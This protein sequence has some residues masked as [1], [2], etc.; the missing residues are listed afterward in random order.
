MYG[1]ARCRLAFWVK[2]WVVGDR[3]IHVW[4]R[5]ASQANLPLLT[6]TT[7]VRPD[8][9]DPD[10]TARACRMYPEDAVRQGCYLARTDDTVRSR[11][12]DISPLSSKPWT[13]V[14][15]VTALNIIDKSF[16]DFLTCT[17][18]HSFTEFPP[19]PCFQI[20]L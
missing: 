14:Q 4:L 17:C 19:F 20:G 13:L 7:P 6:T 15:S 18:I 3:G 12:L 2:A 9:R 5:C 11:L 8:A 16:H 1:I 10:V